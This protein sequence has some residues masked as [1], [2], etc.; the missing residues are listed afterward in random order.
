[1]ASVVPEVPLAMK[2]QASTAADPER[3]SLLP[4]RPRRGVNSNVCDLPTSVSNTL[5][6]RNSDQ[7]INTD[8]HTS[9]SC[10]NIVQRDK[11]ADGQ[12]RFGEACIVAFCV[13]FQKIVLDF[14][15]LFCFLCFIFSFSFF[16]FFFFHVFYFFF[17]C[18]FCFILVFF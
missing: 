13:F 7:S 17:S 8:G 12:T 4:C 9:C 6:L 11:C 15:H 10:V 18:F 16:S 2:A 14:S 5:V 1:M 3:T